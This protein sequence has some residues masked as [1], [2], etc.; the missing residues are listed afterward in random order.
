MDWRE[1]IKKTAAK[2]RWIPDE[3]K[4]AERE[5]E[6]LTS[7]KDWMISKKRFWGLALPIWECRD[8]GQFTVIGSREELEERAIEGWSEF[9]SKERSP[10]RPYLDKIKVACSSCNAP[11][12]RI[13]DVGNPWLDAG[14]VAYSTVSYFEDPEYWNRWIP[15][16][17][18]TE[19]FPGQF[20]NWFYAILAMST[21]MEKFR[22]REATERDEPFEPRAPFRNLLGHALVRDEN[23]NAMHKSDGT[24]IWFEEAAEQLGVDTIRWMFCSQAPTTDLAFGLRYPDEEVEVE[25]PD[26]TPISH[27]VDGARICKVTSSPANEPVVASSSPCGIATPSFATTHAWMASTPV[28]HRFHSRSALP[29][30]AGSSQIFNS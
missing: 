19:C 20:R 22:A 11:T 14:I 13:E 18:V 29:S 27:T 17:L 25:G 5:Q 30:T 2:V 10:H 16:D 8:C 6:W 1:E 28:A 3:M 4:G 15:A 26:G 21:M 9:A 24:A 12:S 23:G 7:M